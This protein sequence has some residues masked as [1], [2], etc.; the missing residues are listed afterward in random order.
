[1]TI[2]IGLD[3]RRLAGQEKYQSPTQ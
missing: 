3:I 2:H 1:M